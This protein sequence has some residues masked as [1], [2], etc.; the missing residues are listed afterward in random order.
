MEDDPVGE[1]PAQVCLRAE[2][3]APGLARADPQLTAGFEALGERLGAQ[4]LSTV[5]TACV[6][7]SNCSKAIPT[8]EGF[9]STIVK[10]QR[11]RNP[12]SSSACLLSTISQATRPA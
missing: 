7:I 1:D 4:M 3:A 11:I 10:V 2:G 9:R 12:R 6:A 8:S 5:P